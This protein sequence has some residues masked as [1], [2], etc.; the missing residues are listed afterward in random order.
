MRKIKNRPPSYL[1]IKM[2]KTFQRRGSTSNTK[3]GRDFEE[4]A[5]NFFARKNLRLIRKFKI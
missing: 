1:L 4:E 5:L 3:V 2:D